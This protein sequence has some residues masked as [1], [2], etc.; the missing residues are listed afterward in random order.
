MKLLYCQ[1]CESIFNLD[2]SYKTCACGE[3]KGFYV[4]RE[5]IVYSGLHAICLGINNDIFFEGT[6]NIPLD[7]KGFQLDSYVIPYYC[8]S[9]IKVGDAKKY[10][11]KYGLMYKNAIKNVWDDQISNVRIKNPLLKL[12]YKIFKKYI[13]VSVPEE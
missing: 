9:T 5:N 7:G 13:F 11:M 12:I 10:Y 4:S 8:G 2:W 1:K 6:T 3:T